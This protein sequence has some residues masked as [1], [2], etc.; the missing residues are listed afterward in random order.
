MRMLE[1][2]DEEIKHRRETQTEL[3]LAK[4]DR[5]QL[6]NHYERER[7]VNSGIWFYELIFLQWR[8][9][10][11]D[12]VGLLY[13]FLGDGLTDSQNFKGKSEERFR[14]SPE[15]Y[16]C[17]PPDIRFTGKNRSNLKL[18]VSR[19]LVMIWVW[20][21]YHSASNFLWNFFWGQIL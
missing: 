13:L 12:Q 14:D 16:F 17:V 10:F 1:T 20:F 21:F 8:E 15:K 9:F 4:A 5:E 19:S 7:E 18:S 6:L 11:L 2:L 3:E